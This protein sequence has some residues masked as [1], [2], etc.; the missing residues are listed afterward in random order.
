MQMNWLQLMKAES[1]V[2]DARAARC[3]RQAPPPASTL[4]SRRVQGHLI[5]FTLA[6]RKASAT[7]CFSVPHHHTTTHRGAEG[8][9]IVASDLPRIACHTPGRCT[10][11][12]IC[13]PHLELII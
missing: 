11:A 10:S 12:F 1:R 4:G 3:R 7:L 5:L 13:Q 8:G 6:S 9:L 2:S